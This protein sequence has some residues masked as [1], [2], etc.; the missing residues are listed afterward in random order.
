[1]T[2]RID[3]LTAINLYRRQGFEPWLVLVN[4]ARPL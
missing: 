1:M 3:N 4:H 2:V